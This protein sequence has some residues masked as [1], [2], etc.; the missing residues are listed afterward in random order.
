[1][2]V[3]GA[4]AAGLVTTRWLTD[5]GFEPVVFE[6]ERGLG[7]LWREGSGLAYRSLRTNTSKQKTAFSDLPFDES[8]PHFPGRDAVLGYLERFADRFELRGRIRFSTPVRELR[9]ENGG[10]AVNGEPFDAAVVCTGLFSRAI[11]P[12]LPGRELFAGSIVHS[13]DY[14]TPEP[15]AGQAVIVVGAG[16]SAN[17][18]ACELAGVARSVHL[19]IR[20]MPTF[21]PR[22]YRGRPFDHRATRLARALPAV[23][24]DRWMWLALRGEYRARGFALDRVTS[25]RTPGIEILD[26]IASGRI[27]VHR[28]GVASLGTDGV[29]F[30][31]GTSARADAVICATGHAVEFPFL[32][33]DVPGR[34]D[35]ALALYR[36]VFPPSVRRLAFVGM[37]RVE[38]PVFPIAEIQAR[39]VVAVFA[40]RGA[41]P[42]ESAMRAEIDARVERAR[43]TGTDPMRVNLLDYLDDIAARI[44]A[45][46][47][48]LRHPRLLLSPVSAR[49]YRA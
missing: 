32:P 14:R 11:V 10:W 45:R 38:G 46:P 48:L 9:S 33:A 23:L 24:R 15:F 3:I 41:L 5:A 17:D 25:K 36:L 6:R 39:W 1:V 8:L 30:S 7:G 31:D 12:E 19:A 20:D 22:L 34:R 28:G 2:A 13:R 21:T 16:S 47:S 40:G 27:V 37:C 35:G 29:R 43:A 44:G 26:E 4:G 42:S 49:D 18:I